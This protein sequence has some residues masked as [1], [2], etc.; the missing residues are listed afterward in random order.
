MRQSVIAEPDLAAFIT[1]NEVKI[2]VYKCLLQQPGPRPNVEQLW[3]WY[4]NVTVLFE[5]LLPEIS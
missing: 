4:Y 5:L 3:L 2:M 1:V